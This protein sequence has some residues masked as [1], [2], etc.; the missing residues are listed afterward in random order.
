[1]ICFEL[2]RLASQLTFLSSYI[3]LVIKSCNQDPF[4]PFEL[5]L[6]Y[7]MQIY[8]SRIGSA[9]S[10]FVSIPFRVSSARTELLILSSSY[11]HKH[12]CMHMHTHPHAPTCTPTYTYIAHTCTCTPTY[13]HLH[14]HTH[15]HIHCTY[16]HMHTNIHPHASTCTHT[17]TCTYV[18]HA[19]TC[20]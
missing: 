19:C 3:F 13:R 15:A 14:A 1:L 6:L 17:C 20:T 12:A 9:Q 5:L 4:D 2:L 11:I 16:M 18:A 8:M 10:G 7:T